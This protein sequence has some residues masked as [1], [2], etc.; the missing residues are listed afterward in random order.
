MARALGVKFDPVEVTWGTAIA[1]LQSNKIDIMYMMDAT[2]ERAQAVDFPKAP[3]LYY[4][5]A[6]LA[7]DGLKVKT[8][9]DL[10][11]PEVRIA[12]PQASRSEEHTS[13]LQSLMRI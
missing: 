3:L 7:K 1:A 6:V 11:K 5:L 13:E 2:P 4:S 10:N 9:E 8:W 12:V